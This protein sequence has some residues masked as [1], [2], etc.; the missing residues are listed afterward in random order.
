MR[1]K[2]I[3]VARVDIRVTPTEYTRIDTSALS[4]SCLHSRPHCSFRCFHLSFSSL[5][6]ATLRCDFD[7]AT[8][9][10]CACTVNLV[11]VHTCTCRVDSRL[12]YVKFNL[13][14]VKVYKNYGDDCL[15][16]LQKLRHSRRSLCVLSI[17]RYSLR[18]SWS[19]SGSIWHRLHLL[20]HNTHP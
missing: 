3:G 12:L 18:E 8:Q 10:S 15:S 4:R 7:R 9:H 2:M 1:L 6:P 19:G 16:L 5:P 20:V 13:I 17:Y 14:M 11:L